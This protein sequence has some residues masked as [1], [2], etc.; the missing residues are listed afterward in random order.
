M[1]ANWFQSMLPSILEEYEGKDVFNADEAVLFYRCLLSKILSFKGQSCSERKPSKELI[2]VLEGCNSDGSEKLPL[3]VIGKR[4][5]PQ[6][7]KNVRTLLVEYTANK[8]AWM[9][10]DWTTMF[11]DCIVKLD[12]RFLREKHKVGLIIDNCPAHPNTVL[13]AIKFIFLPPNTTSVLQPCDQG[14]IQNMKFFY[15]K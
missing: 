7:F 15:R 12:E 8:K 5:K 9:I 4:L 6:C 2:T 14:I 13:K 1:T 3:F 11:T 10:T